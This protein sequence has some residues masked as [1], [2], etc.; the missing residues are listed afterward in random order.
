ML[1]CKIYYILTLN[2]FAYYLTLFIILLLFLFNEL[3]VSDK[4]S[5]TYFNALLLTIGLTHISD[6]L[7][8]LINLLDNE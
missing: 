5:F 8:H 7:L 6:I 1:I 2:I 3:F 4:I